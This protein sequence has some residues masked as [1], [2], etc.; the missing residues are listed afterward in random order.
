MSFLKF[1][2]LVRDEPPG[3]ASSAETDT[4]RKIVDELD[5]LPPEQASYL[6]AFAYILSRVA[7]ADLH[8]SE[9]ETRAMEGIVIE[10]GSLPEEQAIIVVQMAKTQ[11]L[12]FGATE[13]YL[14]TREFNKLADRAQKMALL[15]CLYAVSAADHTISAAEDKVIRQIADE[16]LLEHQDFIEVR[17]RFRDHLAV[18][19]S[20]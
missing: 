1:L 18:F 11:N 15:D 3:R 19:K 14:V 6:A 2:G 12:L 5:H 7:R 17:T 4:V 9:E 8:I 10:H 13:D 16:L 20:D